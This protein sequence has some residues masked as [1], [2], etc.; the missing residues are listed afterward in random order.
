MKKYSFLFL[1]LFLALACNKGAR[2][3]RVTESLQV[4]STATRVTLQD[5]VNAVWNTGDQVSVFYEGGVNE[6][7][8]YVGA[9]KAPKGQIQH[10][11]TV[12]RVGLGEFVALWPYDSGASI[13]GDV[14]STTVPAVQ[15][16]SPNSYSWGILVS[17]TMDN[18]LDFSYATAFVKLSLRG[19]GKVTK[20]EL[21]GN[22]SE[23]LAGVASV[24]VSGAYPV[25]TLPGGSQKLTLKNGDDSVMA[26]L[27]DGTNDFWMGLVP[28]TFSNGFTLTVTLSSGSTEDI[29]V[30]GPL[31]LEAGQAFCVHATLFGFETVI[32]D[33]VNNSSAFSPALPT[34]VITTEGVHTYNSGNGTYSLTFHP[35][36]DSGVYGY[37]FYNHVDF[38]KSMLI[39]KKGGWIKLPV[40]TG[41]ALFE[42]EYV[43]GS[44]SGHPFLTDNTSDPFNHMLSNQVGDTTGNT[45]YSMTLDNPVKNKQYY[46]IVGSGNLLMKKMILRYIKVD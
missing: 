33:F 3:A 38:G 20:V 45:S 32:I 27:E 9:D 25:A 24:D 17:K 15:S 35:V 40:K 5:G 46:L 31:T 23:V 6:C 13:S 21:S 1:V 36:S 41:Y 7:W 43:S 34:S 16:Y 4:G 37:G 42:V 28:G 8:D 26:D 39:G 30:S 44:L 14:I 18:S 11:S 10:G 22:N 19:I 12:D 29:R 2:P